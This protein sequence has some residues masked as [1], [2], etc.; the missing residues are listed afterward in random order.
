MMTQHK[1]FGGILARLGGMLLLGLL[2]G[3]PS[4]KA[5]AQCV[6]PPQAFFT[7]E[8]SVG[9]CW[10]WLSFTQS[11]GQVPFGYYTYTSAG[12]MDH[13]DLGW[14]Y[15][16]DA[17]SSTCVGC[18]YFYDNTST[19]YFFTSPSLFPYL[20]DY[21]LNVWLWY[22]PDVTQPGNYTSNPRFFVNLS[23]DQVISLGSASSA[24]NY[25]LP[26]VPANALTINGT[27]VGTTST[28]TLSTGTPQSFAFTY[29]DPLGSSEIAWGQDMLLDSSLGAHCYLSWGP[30]SVDLYDGTPPPPGTMSDAFCSVSP[31]SVLYSAS[32]QVTIPFTFFQASPNAYSVI[33]QVYDISGNYGPWVQVGSVTLVAQTVP[34]SSPPVPQAPPDDTPAPVVP[35]P[36][37]QLATNCN[38]ISGTW[39][40]GG[41]S[42]TLS[43]S[44]S[45]V[46][47]TALQPSPICSQGLRWTINGQA[48]ASPGS[49]TLA[50]QGPATDLCGNPVVTIEET[51]SATLSSCSTLQ[52]T[53]T[54]S[55]GATGQSSPAPLLTIQPPTT[56]WTGRSTPPGISVTV[57]L[58]NDQ[59]STTLSG[60][61]KT[62]NLSIVMVDAS[63]NSTTLASH[64]NASAGA[65]FTGSGGTTPAD[66]LQ[67]TALAVGQY[68]NVTATWDDTAVTVPVTFYVNGLTRFS[69]Y[70]TPYAQDSTCTANQQTAYIFNGMDANYC[71]YTSNTTLGSVFMSQVAINGTGVIGTNTVVKSYNAGAKTICAQLPPGATT[72]NTF[73]AIDTGGNPIKYITGTNNSALSDATMFPSPLNKNNQPAGSVAAYP[74]PNNA[75][76]HTNVPASPFSFGDQILVIDQNDAN[77]SLG[78]RSVQDLCPGCGPGSFGSQG[79]WGNTVAHIDMYSSSHVCQ[80]VN[81]YG[82]RTAIRLR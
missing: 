19:H 44:G 70:N 22:V 4:A 23:T 33:T 78:P 29:T 49:F 15:V 1:G 41:S 64:P 50:D 9:S 62:G 74:D 24:P 61:N 46:T 66:S 57:D 20:Y 10:Y 28:V 16:F 26:Q 12:W 21:T 68:G 47:G 56:T 55:T 81:D 14:E 37:Q 77:D 65:S 13:L 54:S 76:N 39:Y 58:M 71:Y 82:N 42:M 59:V 69:Q 2:A 51:A 53:V 45:T 27:V 11:S 36:V 18:V 17:N 73:F 67:R 60:Q 75:Q 80:G 25:S 30:N 40:D 38:D 63:G 6:V 52:V 35:A 8:Q 48:T 72:G 5:Q 43:Q 79:G 3:L 31:A 32:A 34:V 7:G